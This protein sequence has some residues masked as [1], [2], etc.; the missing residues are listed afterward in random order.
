MRTNGVKADKGAWASLCRWSVVGLVVGSMGCGGPFQRPE[1]YTVQ[2]KNYGVPVMF[3]K[4]PNAQGGRPIHAESG[5][6]ASASSSTSTSGNVTTTISSSSRAESE[7]GASRKILAQLNRSDRWVQV[8][9]VM[10]VG[11]DL[12][13]YGYS[14][15]KRQLKIDAEAHR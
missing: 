6:A 3:S 11:Y 15:A 4:T 12:A 2:A 7:M 5:V 9:D 1:L 14:M 10:Y 8:V 13:A